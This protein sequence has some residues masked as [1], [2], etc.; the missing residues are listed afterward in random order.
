MEYRSARTFADSLKSKSIIA[1]ATAAM[2]IAMAALL[3]MAA[4]TDALAAQSTSLT[5]AATKTV[6]V[7]QVKSVKVKAGAEKMTITFKKGKNGTKSQVA[8]KKAGAKKWT[9]KAVDKK[10][11]VTI[12]KLTGNTKYSVKV[13]SYAKVGKKTIRGKWSAIKTAKPTIN[14]KL[15]GSWQL[16]SAKA[17]ESEP[18][19]SQTKLLEV[20]G[21]GFTPEALEVGKK[22]EEAQNAETPPSIEDLMAMAGFDLSTYFGGKEPNQMQKM[23]MEK[24][25]EEITAAANS[26]ELTPT[27]LGL[28]KSGGGNLTLDVKGNNKAVFELTGAENNP[29]VTLSKTKWNLTWKKKTTKSATLKLEGYEKPIPAK[30]SGDNLVIEIEGVTA[31]FAKVQQSK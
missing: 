1:L 21:I 6:K 4:P 28:M 31:T 23:F 16:Y 13:R 18:A 12:K 22:I 3:C 24:L 27:L 20:L 19:A 8:Y 26:Q 30:M 9:V 15:I 29:Y 14:S 7:G 10:T 5:T 2:A 17:A 25:K 11:K